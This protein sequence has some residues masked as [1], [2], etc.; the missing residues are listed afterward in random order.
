[1]RNMKRWQRIA[2][3]ALTLL[4]PLCAVSGRAAEMPEN[5]TAVETA[6]AEPERAQTAAPEESAPSETTA[7][8][9]APE[10]AAP[11]AAETAAPETTETA[12]PAQ[13][14]SPAPAQTDTPAP[15]ATDSPAATETAG[16]L[17]TPSPSETTQAP[18]VSPSASPEASA[19][20]SSTPDA[21]EKKIIESFVLQENPEAKV[22]EK[23][24]LDEVLAKLPSSIGVRLSDETEAEAAISWSCAD[25]SEDKAEYQFVAALT[26]PAFAV[27][28]GVALPTFRLIVEGEQRWT[29][30]AF[31]FKR[32][33][34]QG[35]MLIAYGGES[36]EVVIPDS[37]EGLPVLT[38]ARSAFAQNAK[39]QKVIVPKGVIAL[40]DGAFSGCTS[41]T[42]VELPDSL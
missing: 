13:T 2:A 42:E 36:T 11:T 15:A 6:S 33:N 9:A 38:V 41:L 10:T 28:E 14:D 24:T 8:T 23:P 25:Y 5:P 27:A 26:D 31:V 4:F 32:W 7:E 16:P 30:G 3:L 19:E 29:S 12:A 40:E 1:M 34:E 20:P 18:S 21:G 35:L 17:D 39:L 22:Q 37:V